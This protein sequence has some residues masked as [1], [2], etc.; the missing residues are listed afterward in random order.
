MARLFVDAGANL[1][2][3]L[4]RFVKDLPG[5][6]F[7]AF[8]PNPALLPGLTVNAGATGHPNIT[9]HPAAV[10]TFDGDTDLYLGHH[11]SSTLLTGKRVPP[12]YNQQIDYEHPIRVDCIDFSTWLANTASPRDHVIVKMDIEGAEYPVLRR[13]AEA[14]TLSLIDILYV[15]WHVDRFATMP[16]EEHDELYATVAAALDLRPWD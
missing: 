14:G 10:W 5:Y 1:G 6:E 13:M 2:I 15:E 11:E 4:S 3:V 9:I 16:Q 12:Q 7:H 8:E